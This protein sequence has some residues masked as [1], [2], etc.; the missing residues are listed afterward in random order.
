MIDNSDRSP[1][2]RQIVAGDV[3]VTPV[4]HH[5]A[6]G[7]V[8]A[9][10]RTQTPIEAQDHLSDALSR[11][12]EL[13]AGTAHRVFAY[14]NAGPGSSRSQVNCRT[15]SGN[16]RTP[17]ELGTVVMFHASDDTVALMQAL[18][19]EAGASQTLIHCPLAD[20][21]RGIT[22]FRKHLHQHNPE[23]V[24]FDISPPYA[25]NW[26]FF[27]AIRDDAVMRRRGV[28]LTTT[29][30]QRLDEM[31]GE[32]TDAVEVVGGHLNRALILAEINAATRLARAASRHANGG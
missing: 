25:E 11:A 22:D 16:P 14:E 12:C 8:N 19:T 23:V 10:H 13:V 4:A 28:V 31:V 17:T 24:I 21:K 2:L 1:D 18:L 27:T 32:D 15:I 29:N 6:L 20:L 26:T 9:N 3:V 30:K 7:R 5:Y